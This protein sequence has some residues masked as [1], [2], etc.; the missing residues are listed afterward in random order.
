MIPIKVILFS[1]WVLLWK[2]TE[3]ANNPACLYPCFGHYPEML[4]YAPFNLM[5]DCYESLFGLDAPRPR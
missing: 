3:I 1:H 5:K 4:Q 2:R